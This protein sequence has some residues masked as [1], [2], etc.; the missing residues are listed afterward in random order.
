MLLWS[1]G[2]MINFIYTIIPCTWMQCIK[3]QV[4]GYIDL[5]LNKLFGHFWIMDL[6]THLNSELNWI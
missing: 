4:L 6:M 3:N 2:E 1:F 5:A